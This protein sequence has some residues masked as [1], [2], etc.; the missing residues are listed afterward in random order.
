[1]II[2]LYGSLSMYQQSNVVVNCNN[3][4]FPK[5]VNCDRRKRQVTGG[6]FANAIIHYGLD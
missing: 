4:V 3:A 2:V 6:P 5:L 1:M